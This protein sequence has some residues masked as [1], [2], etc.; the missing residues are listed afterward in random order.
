MRA[1][2]WGLAA[3]VATLAQP[4][5]NPWD[6]ELF[7]YWLTDDQYVEFSGS[8]TT[9]SPFWDAWEGRDSL[10]MTPDSNACGG[11]TDC[12]ESGD[13]EV[14]IKAAGCRDGLLMLYL[15]NDD[16]WVDS[17]EG[18]FSAERLTF[19]HDRVSADSI[20]RC[21]DCLIE[22]YS[23]TLTN[24]YRQGTVQLGGAGSA[25]ETFTLLGNDPLWPCEICDVVFTMAEAREIG[26]LVDPVVGPDGTKAI[27]VL[28]PWWQ[29]STTEVFR[30][31]PVGEE[32]V[33]PARGMRF[34]YSADYFDVDV[35]G[36]SCWLSWQEE[37]PWTGYFWG[38]LV[39]GDGFPAE[40]TPVGEL[41]VY[42]ESR[43]R[44]PV[45]QGDQ[46]AWQEVYDLAGRTVGPGA[47]SS[48]TAV[49]ARRGT[50]RCRVAVG[51][52]HATGQD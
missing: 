9:L 3:W 43:Q 49:V 24:N 23:A 1:G 40:P 52:Q 46:I 33:V 17:A 13:A 7:V 30:L 18:G 45:V 4:V 36:D 8:D 44:W 22:M 41:G 15:V 26:V 20:R 19:Y 2:I 50:A 31:P 38:D 25:A 39:F 27:E 34:A 32:G 21:S 10:V 37:T 6:S 11:I 5:V 42:G 28:L 47:R 51:R 16:A 35:A 48:G 12:G 29:F 14:T